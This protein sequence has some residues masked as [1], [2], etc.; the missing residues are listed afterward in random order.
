MSMDISSVVSKPITVLSKRINKPGGKKRSGG[1][2]SGAKRAPGET[3]EAGGG[4]HADLN[5]RDARQDPVLSSDVD[6][7]AHLSKLLLLHRQPT[8]S[9]NI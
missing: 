3:R 1:G 2:G 8:F 6:L 5:R 7:A 9:L 4:V